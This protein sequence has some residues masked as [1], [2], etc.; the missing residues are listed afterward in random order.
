[1]IEYFKM[2]VTQKYA[3]FEGRSTRSEF[4]YFFLVYFLLSVVL[5]LVGTLSVIMAFDRGGS[6][7]MAWLCLGILFLLML[8]LLV[9]YVAVS[10]RR[11]H[12]SGKSG[13]WF[14]LNFVPYIGFLFFV[15][16]MCLDSEAGTNEYG[17]NPFNLDGV[18]DISG[19]L[20]KDD[21]I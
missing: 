12:D 11:L 17:P 7:S 15:V 9:P 20:L 18:G 3:Q 10:I 4:W 21:F 6:S 19:H 16:L 13:W 2:A 1:M 14:M 8:V 5:G